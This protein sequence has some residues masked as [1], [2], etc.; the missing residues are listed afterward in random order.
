M[1]TEEKLTVL[2]LAKQYCEDR[3]MLAEQRLMYADAPYL[4]KQLQAKRNVWERQLKKVDGFISEV[5]ADGSLHNDVAAIT[6]N[7]LQR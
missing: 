3:M 6:T 2:G 1:K 5:K 4:I 7:E